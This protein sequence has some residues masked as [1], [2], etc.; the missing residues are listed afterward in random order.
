[1]GGNAFASGSDPL[2]TPRMPP[3]V[4]NTTRQACLDTLQKLF[5]HVAIPV[6]GPAKSDYGDIDIFLSQD[7]QSPA[8]EGPHEEGSTDTARTSLEVAARE[9][10]AV[11]TISANAH[12]LS[13]AIPWPKD[14]PYQSMVVL[15]S[16]PRRR[17]PVDPLTSNSINP[18]WPVGDGK[19]RSTE[20]QG[21]LEDRY[22]QVDLHLK[23]SYEEMRWM[24]FRYGHGDM[25]N[26]LG[27]IIRPFGLT[28][29]EVGLHIRIPEIE[30]SNRKNCRV[31]LT[32]DPERVLDFLGLD[33]D[34]GQWE[35]PFKT[36]DE[37]FD[38]AA[39]CRLFFVR[40]S[41]EGHGESMREE[42]LATGRDRRRVKAR[43]LYRQWLDEFL[44]TC[45][46]KGH[47][48]SRGLTRETVRDEA[49]STFGVRQEWESR[50]AAFRREQQRTSL[51][52]EV[53][54]PALPQGD[55]L[56]ETPQMRG[57]AAATMKKVIMLGD[58]S[59]GDES[60]AAEAAQL[61]DG[62]GVYDEKA[63]GDFVRAHWRATLA[64]AK[65]RNRQNQM[66]R[67]AEEAKPKATPAGAESVRASGGVEG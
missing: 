1:M 58:T 34:D 4:Y 33:H 55:S 23:A 60:L 37:A 62:E 21:G 8:N 32:K 3:D 6:E 59:F 44:A 9:L 17:D 16:I 27:S 12:V 48:R 5:R 54:K 56:I 41:G 2:Y 40:P 20:S 10:G 26:I 25:W 53:I 61:K 7:E 30:A 15:E 57:L 39:C 43:P 19:L 24:L 49:L 11:R 52:R 18:Y 22:I 64:V 13:A 28:A 63:V 31:L 50:L 42:E 36:V 46:A 47:C 65:E 51:A 38:Y 14:H 67:K 35:R 66:Q 45:R 29:D